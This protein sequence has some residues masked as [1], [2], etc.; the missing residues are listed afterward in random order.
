MVEYIYSNIVYYISEY[1][2][3]NFQNDKGTWQ[4]GAYS[5]FSITE[6][7]SLDIQTYYQTAA[8]QGVFNMEP[9]L[10][11]DVSVSA[12]FLK[13]KLVVNLAVSDVFNSYEEASQINFE[14]QDSFV[15]QTYDMRR[16]TLE[17]KYNF[18]L[19]KK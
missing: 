5:L 14:N 15:S 4:F 3:N 18:C 10:K 7:L 13:K 2:I 12:L 9:L 1:E 8:V 6:S 16:L 19:V 17:L 11:T